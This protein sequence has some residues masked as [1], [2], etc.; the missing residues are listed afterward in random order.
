[1]SHLAPSRS[2]EKPAKLR[3][4]LVKNKKSPENDVSGPPAKR[5]RHTE[6]DL[7]NDH[8]ISFSSSATPRRN[9]AANQLLNRPLLSTRPEPP[10]I[11][12][13]N[14]SETL[15]SKKINPS[16]LQFGFLGLGIMGSGIVKNLINSG[17]KVIVWNRTIAKCRKFA[18]AGAEIAQT[19]SDVIDRADIT[20]S[21]VSDPSAAKQ[22]V[23]G[24]CG[25]LSSN[26]ISEGKGYVEMTSIDAETSND[27]ADAIIS[28][29]GR[30]LEAQI[31]G[32]KNQAEEGTLIILAAGDR[33]LFDECQT[34]FEAMG[35][36]SFYL[37][38]VGNASKM[39]CVLQMIAG[40]SLATL[41]EGLSLGEFTFLSAFVPSLTP[42]AIPI[43]S[44]QSRSAAEGRAGSIRADEHGVPIAAREG[45]R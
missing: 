6:G 22:M 3:S 16:L 42:V 31:Q 1:M 38:E 39:N 12:M 40:V 43:R 35:K 29:G 27:I 25:V 20:F 36:N 2:Q 45:Q 37:G 7:H 18:E 10:E 23:L 4:I 34:C 11:D 17:H 24:N 19:P 9:D 30:Y 5:S 33:S 41:A 32:S 15:K 44:K 13:Q 26:S 28:K 8:D 14:V 21:C